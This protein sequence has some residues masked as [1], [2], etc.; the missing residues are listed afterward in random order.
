MV[1]DSEEQLLYVAND[2]EV[3]AFRHPFGYNVEY[4]QISRIAHN[5][6]ITGM[7][8]YLQGNMIIWSTQFNP[9]GIFYNT[10]HGRAGK[11]T[12]SGLIVSIENY[13]CNIYIFYLK[14]VLMGFGLVLM[15]LVRD[16]SKIF[17]NSFSCT[18]SWNLLWL[19]GFPFPKTCMRMH[20]LY[21]CYLWQPVNV[22]IFGN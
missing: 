14:L 7:D 18:C 22:Q 2:T 21:I 1:P 19:L 16:S 4:Q 15:T 20:S 3:L 10:F 11:E 5:S 12:K 9:G 8:T 17:Q 13:C 6:R